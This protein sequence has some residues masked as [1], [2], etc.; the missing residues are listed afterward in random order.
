MITAAAIQAPQKPRSVNV[1]LLGLNSFDEA[2][3]LYVN[4]RKNL[5]EILSAFEFFDRQCLELV[6]KH[7]SPVARNP[8]QQ[9]YPFYVLIETHGSNA[10]HDEQKL[11]QFLSS[12]V[13]EGIAMDGTFGFDEAM[14]C[15]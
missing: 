11:T 15:F 9:L 8:F 13:D 1:A 3:Q 10:Q 12:T 7:Q 6:L 14:V 2:Q 5:G 4:T